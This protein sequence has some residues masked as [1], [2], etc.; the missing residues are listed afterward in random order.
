MFWFGI[1]FLIL[2]GTFGLNIFRI[3]R[4]VVFGGIFAII[5]LLILAQFLP[6]PPK[7]VA[8]VEPAPKPRP[9][10]G[11]MKEAGEPSPTPKVFTQQEKSQL[12]VYGFDNDK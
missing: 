5:G 9:N 2:V 8:R 4:W 7:P 10:Y 12:F 1:V 11:F 6:A 3:L